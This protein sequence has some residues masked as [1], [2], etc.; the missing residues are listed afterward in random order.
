MIIFFINKNNLA[1]AYKIEL[2]DVKDSLVCEIWQATYCSDLL[3]RVYPVN[4][5]QIKNSTL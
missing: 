4:W 2:N 3:M 1:Q 5:R